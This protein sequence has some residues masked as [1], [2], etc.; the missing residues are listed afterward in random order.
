MKAAQ[1]QEIPASS[2]LLDPD[3]P[4]K[5]SREQ[6]QAL[7][8]VIGKYGNLSDIWV[9]RTKDGRF[10]I[11][12]GEHRFNALRGDRHRVDPVQSA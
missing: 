11:V 10:R 5:M 7:K 6:R 8:T 1:R 9:T 12:D 4:N 2:I 3:N